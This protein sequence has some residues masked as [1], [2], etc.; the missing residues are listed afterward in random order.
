MAKIITHVKPNHIDDVL[1]TAIALVAFDAGKVVT[2]RDLKDVALEAG[3]IVLDIGGK[4]GE[5]DGVL[6]FDHHQDIN[7]PATFVLVLRHLGLDIT[8][9]P[10]IFEDYL[11]F[12][13]KD[14]R[15]PKAAE[16]K[17][18]TR[19]LGDPC[20]RVLVKMFETD[21]DVNMFK[22]IGRA[23]LDEIRKRI[24]TAERYKGL[25]PDADGIVWAKDDPFM[26]ITLL[27]KM[28][29]DAIAVISKNTRG[30]Y[31]ITR[32]AHVEPE[33]FSPRK[34][35]EERGLKITFE[36]ATGFLVVVEDI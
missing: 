32:L 27:A 12:S 13:E 8:Q 22:A 28:Q 3:D 4:L 10:E 23:V 15:G 1:A 29:P 25:C 11:F 9:Y 35:A 20:E 14:A 33:K 31:S 36:H 16:I 34:F 5:E 24:E 17:F 6:Y 2:A 19:Y 21:P 30:G 7:L 26:N 18:G